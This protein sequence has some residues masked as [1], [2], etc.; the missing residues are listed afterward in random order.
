M[1]LDISDSYVDA[2]GNITFNG[3]IVKVDLIAFFPDQKDP[4]KVL[5]RLIGRMV[6]SITAISQ[7]RDGLN[8]MAD[9]LQKA[10][11]KNKKKLK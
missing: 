10:E 8:K 5:P 2:F 11:E 6:T 9:D 3:H 1:S 4:Q 7:L